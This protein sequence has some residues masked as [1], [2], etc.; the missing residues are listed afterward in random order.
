MSDRPTP[1][2]TTADFT[3]ADPLLFNEAQRKWFRFVV[4]DDYIALF[5]GSGG[6]DSQ[7][8]EYVTTLNKPYGK[9]IWERAV[10]QG[11]AKME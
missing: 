4:F 2:K 3:A 9:I 7:T 6:K 10:E 8:W 5:E 1:P 11:F